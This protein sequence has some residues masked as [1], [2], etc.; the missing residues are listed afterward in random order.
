LESPSYPEYIAN[1]RRVGCPEQTIGD[2]IAADLTSLFA[3]R[4]AAAAA[5]TA[6]PAERGRLTA[7]LDREE[8]AVRE[9]LLAPLV[10]TAPALP[11]PTA[12]RRRSAASAPPSA[13]EPAKDDGLLA[14]FNERRD[15][16]A[17]LQHLYRDL[18]PSE[19]ELTLILHLSQQFQTDFGTPPAAPDAQWERRRRAAIQD[20]ED[21]LCSLIGY[22]RYNEFLRDAVARQQVGPGGP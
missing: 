16:L 8:S 11:V 5:Q 10:G 12:S 20:S 6:D 15:S 13:A 4:R 3:S 18:K 21:L 22:Q 14:Q 17:Q 2:I 9:Q 1:L 19:A 7:A